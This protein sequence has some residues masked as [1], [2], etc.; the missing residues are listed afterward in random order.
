MP[1]CPV[2]EAF[3]LPGLALIAASTSFTDLYGESARDREAGRVG[4]DERRAACTTRRS[5]SV[6]PC[7]CIIAISTVIMPIV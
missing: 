1:P 7:Q 2:P 3:S 5:S 6:S 4:V